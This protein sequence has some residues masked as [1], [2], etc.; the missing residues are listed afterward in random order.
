[1]HTHYLFPFFLST[2]FITSSF[3]SL[4]LCQP[5]KQLIFYNLLGHVVMLNLLILRLNSQLNRNYYIH[6]DTYLRMFM[7]RLFIHKTNESSILLY[8]Y[9]C[10]Q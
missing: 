2:L 5:S 8:M 1:M 3:Y 10:K 7:D 6:Q 4:H 9:L